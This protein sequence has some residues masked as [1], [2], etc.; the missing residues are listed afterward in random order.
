VVEAGGEESTF[1]RRFDDREVQDFRVVLDEPVD[2]RGLE[3]DIT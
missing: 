2:I 1:R 3:R